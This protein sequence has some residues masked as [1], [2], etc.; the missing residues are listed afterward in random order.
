[1]STPL[2][3]FE[4]ITPY[5]GPVVTCSYSMLDC[6]QQAQHVVHD[7]RGCLPVCSFHARWRSTT[8]CLMGHSS[9]CALAPAEE[10]P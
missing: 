3:G 4:H 7:K 5:T 1:M 2:G 8:S 9:D 10:A 6:T